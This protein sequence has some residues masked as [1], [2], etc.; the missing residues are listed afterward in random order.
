MR[1]LILA[2]NFPRHVAPDGEDLR[3]LHFCRLLSERHELLFASSEATPSASPVTRYFKHIFTL[4]KRPTENRF[5]HGISRWLRAFSPRELHPLDSCVSAQLRELLAEQ[6]IDLIWIPSWSMMPY[7]EIA[8]K[9]PIVLDVMDDGVLELW[10]ELKR[11]SSC[12]EIAIKL[13]RLIVT[14]LFERI[15]FPR[16]SLCC[17]VSERDAEVLKRVCPKANVMVI[18]NGVDA[19][20]FKPLDD[21]EDDSILVFEGNMSFPPNADAAVF[22]ASKI[23]PLVLAKKPQM[24]F[25][26]VGKNPNVEVLKF[27]AGNIVV[28]GYVDDIR[29]YLNRAAIFLCP[30]RKGAGIKNKILQAWAMA[31]PIVATSL[32]LGGLHSI[33]GKNIM[34]ADKPAEFA[35]SILELL[36]DEPK[37]RLLGQNGRETVLRHYSWE[38]QVSLLEQRFMESVR[39]YS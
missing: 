24:K 17:L 4:K 29:P 2:R 18:P 3:V 38:K 22:F 36:S 39:V 9:L 23:F 11:A 20:Y 33:V 15:Y 30:M 14:Y 25:Y 37:R 12:R 6:M 7:S 5:T 34:V 13:K 8:R 16:A 35:G 10:R 21:P 28:T 19:D 32:A 31:K 27:A 26:I 1:I